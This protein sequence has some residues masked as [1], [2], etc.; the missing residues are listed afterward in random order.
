VL[1]EGL[2]DVSRVA[3]SVKRLIEQDLDVGVALFERAGHPHLGVVA[4]AIVRPRALSPEVVLRRMMR[5]IAGSER[6]HGGATG[7]LSRMA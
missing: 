6:Q 4:S 3:E 5:L 2:E 7:K 1:V